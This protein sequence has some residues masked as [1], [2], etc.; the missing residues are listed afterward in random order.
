MRKKTETESKRTR[1]V[2]MVVVAAAVVGR[3]DVVRVGRERLVLLAGRAALVALVGELVLVLLVLLVA[4]GVAIIAPSG[5]RAGTTR[6]PVRTRRP[7]HVEQ[8]SE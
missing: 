7:A 3:A 5:R 4:L 1:V 2:V 6:V 8:L